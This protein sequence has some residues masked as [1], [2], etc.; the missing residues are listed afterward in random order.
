MQNI[1]CPHC[2]QK[3][4]ADDTLAGAPAKCPSC[5]GTVFIPKLRSRFKNSLTCGLKQ[6]MSSIIAASAFIVAM[7]TLL[8]QLGVFPRSRLKF[9]TPED[10]IKTFAEV[11]Q[12]GTFNDFRRIDQLFNDDSKWQSIPPEKIEIVKTLEVKDTG[13]SD[14]D[15]G[16][17]CF[18]KFKKSDGVD[19]H[20]VVFLKKTEK[21]LFEESFQGRAIAKD[22]G[23]IIEQWEKNGMLK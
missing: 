9:S 16:V 11:N 20:K 3:I 10:A 7:V 17:L 8:M 6:H 22:Y 18:L 23:A 14:S 19:S 21:G 15:G 12:S 13:D 4:E 5:R 2:Q 1:T